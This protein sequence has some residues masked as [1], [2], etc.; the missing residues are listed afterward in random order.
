MYFTKSAGLNSTKL[1]M[2]SFS[3]AKVGVQGVR[4][5]CEECRPC[6]LCRSPVRECDRSLAWDRGFS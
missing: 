2:A 5:P 4:G 6:R 3:V 1:V